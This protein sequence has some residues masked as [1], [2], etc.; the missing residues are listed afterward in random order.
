MYCTLQ[1]WASKHYRVMSSAPRNLSYARSGVSKRST[2][3]LLCYFSPRWCYFSFL[4]MKGAVRHATH[5][6]T[7]AVTCATARLSLDT[8]GAE[9]AAKKIPGAPLV[10]NNDRSLSQK[11]LVSECC[12][13]LIS[14]NAGLL[15]SN[16]V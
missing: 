10:I 4:V 12:S 7:A 16:F 3:A 11:S 15:R 1:E 2:V 8:P 14:A 6:A 13:V 5:G 9:W